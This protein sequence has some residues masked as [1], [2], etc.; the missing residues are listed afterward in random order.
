MSDFSWFETDFNDIVLVVPFESR[1]IGFS[2]HRI[3][4]CYDK[5]STKTNEF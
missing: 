2:L 5:H 3:K 1:S 4:V